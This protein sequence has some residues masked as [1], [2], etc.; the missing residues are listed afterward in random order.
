VKKR[1]LIVIISLLMWGC[2]GK[3]TTPEATKSVEVVTSN[4]ALMDFVRQIGGDKVS[5]RMLLA[6]GVEA[7]S[8]EPTPRDIVQINKSTLF[9]CV[10]REAEPWVADLLEACSLQEESIVETGEGLLKVSG[11]HQGHSEEDC[12]GGKHDE[13]EHDEGE[14][15]E[16]EHDEGEH[17]EG[18]HDSHASS[19]EQDGRDVMDDCES[20]GTYDPHIWLDPVLAVQISENITESLVRSD[21]MNADY[22]RQRAD[23]FITELKSLDSSFT[24]LFSAVDS[25]AILYAGHFAFGYFAERYGV[26]YYSPYKGFSPNAEPSPRKIGEMIELV[27]EKGFTTIY[28]EELVNPRVA[29]VIVRETGVEMKLLHGIHN[30]SS[31]EMIE[32]FSYIDGM[33]MNR[34]NLAAGLVQ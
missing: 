7:H 6:P 5:V 27:R 21:S 16:G 17:D 31:T 28:F 14:H 10:S 1:V 15:D 9:V 23:S 34:E 29:E 11:D 33:E 12:D 32:E 8:Y 24:E 22:Y 4:F 25:P 26:D 30:V 19:E 18:E 13:D 20:H 2:S 3:S